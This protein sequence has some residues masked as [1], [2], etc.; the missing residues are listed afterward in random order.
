M[1][2]ILPGLIALAA[3]AAAA[4]GAA[5]AA[6]VA[7]AVAV[8]AQDTRAQLP[9][10]RPQQMVDIGGRRLNLYCS[11]AGPVTVV[12]DAAS[13]DAGWSWHA[14]QPEVAKRTRACVYDRAG[15]GFS[16][17]SPMPR[18]S[19]NAVADLHVLLGRAG[20][21]PPYVMVGSSWGADNVQ[22]YA[23]RYPDEVKGL[24]L[25]DA[26]HDDEDERLD[27]VSQG[28]LKAA[29]APMKA[30][31]RQ[32]ADASQGGWSI[33]GEPFASC[34][35]GTGDAYGR[36]LAA[37]RLAIV[38]RP[39]YWQAV[40]SESDGFEAST[41]Q[42]KAA[43]RS[44]GDLPMVLLVRGVSPYAV[45]GR[46]QSALNKATEAVHLAM[47]KELAAYSTRSTVRVVPGAEHVI[48]ETKPEAVVQ[49]VG[50]VLGQVGR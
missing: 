49:A 3:A 43:R 34:T 32:C 38:S 30:F 13:S 27:K 5:P 10:A 1:T 48:H 23:Y 17:P 20:I 50:D 21:A 19:E 12:F 11:G 8:A 2:R 35:G 47:Q 16:D 41:A 18:N 42:M 46:P 14:V 37:A 36:E 28:K 26:S 44:F 24:V 29:M 31:I 7:V 6:A 9:F 25:V 45:P 40:V 15:L 22:L 4:A 33:A 39:G